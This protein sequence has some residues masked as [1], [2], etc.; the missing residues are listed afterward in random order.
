MRAVLW[1]IGLSVVACDADGLHP[2]P[3]PSPS[4]AE[5]TLPRY[6]S[7]ACHNAELSALDQPSTPG[8]RAIHVFSNYQAQAPGL[9]SVVLDLGRSITLVLASRTSAAWHLELLP[10]TVVEEILLVSEHP[11]TVDPPGARV[12]ER[13]S[14]RACAYA[15]GSANCDVVALL[16][17]LQEI[18]GAAP[19]SIHGCYGA[20]AFGLYD[21][22][23]PVRW[24]G[25]PAG[26]DLSLTADRLTVSA[27]GGVGTQ[28]LFATHPRSQGHHY[29]EVEV[30]AGGALEGAIG[31]SNPFASDTCPWSRD[32]S[33]SC[34]PGGKLEGYG[35]GDTLGVAVNFEKLELYY[36]KN[37]RWLSGDPAIGGG[38]PLPVWAGRAGLF[39]SAS[40][41]SGDSLRG[42]FAAEELRYLPPLG[43]TEWRRNPGM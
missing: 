35:P 32:G 17:L 19:T 36:S 4:P 22:Q 1:I 43:F 34:A 39:P 38:L 33:V 42:R 13:T 14:S 29:F 25:V 7:G 23:A 18:Y 28:S 24:D 5:S 12:I 2:A 3:E 27:A 6:A 31:V 11:S 41:A 16:D 9:V 26:P 20:T 8:G 21:A 30:L 10:G 40:L 15:L 37:G